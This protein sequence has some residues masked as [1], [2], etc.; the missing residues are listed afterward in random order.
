MPETASGAERVV[1]ALEAY[2]VAYVF[3]NPGTTE[4]PLLRA[5]A[6]SSVEYVLALHEDVAVAMAAGYAIGSRHAGAT[7]RPVGV[8]NLH[9]APGVAH[10]LGNLY[11]ADRAGAPVLVT[12]GAHARDFQRSRP[13]LGGDLVAMTDQ[14]TKWARETDDPA[15]LPG[16]LRA[17]VEAAT[18]PPTGPGFLALPLD[19]QLAETEAAV[20]PLGNRAPPLTPAE[21]DVA[22]A[23]DAIAAAEAPVLV[24]GDRVAQDGSQAIDAAVRLAEATGARVH[25]EVLPAEASFPPRH[26]QWVSILP[27]DEDRIRTLL[28]ADTLILAGCDSLVPLTA[29]SAPLV[30]P[31]STVV[32]IGYPSDVHGLDLD[33]TV[34]VAGPPGEGLDRL[35]DRLEGAVDPEAIEARIDDL[36]AVRG[37]VQAVMAE[38]AAPEG[39]AADRL[40]KPAVVEALC[41]V[42]PEAYVVDEGVT[43][44]YALR[45]GMALEPGRYL[46]SKGAGLGFG[47]GAAL[48]V[49][50]AV[51]DRPVV[52]FVGD[53]SFL[54]YPQALYT[55]VRRS[56]DVTFLVVDNEGYRI[57]KDN[58][59]AMFDDATAEDYLGMDLA[60]PID[61]AGFGR[62][63]GVSAESVSTPGELEPALASAVE[64]D[65]PAL[66]VARVQD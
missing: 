43:A 10:G 36:E 32:E 46:F 19:V 26:P 5:L 39:D 66:V 58:L 23:A 64:R 17:A 34:R 27:P 65:G 18:T 50:L 33:P 49:A 37:F 16:D 7:D 8:A 4:L 42:A 53:G 9:V 30:D 61:I 31:E 45:A 60:P 21:G 14:F 6:D 22:V 2:G 54:Y 57:L 29:P 13:L 47:A 52:A 56:I 24:V 3:G 55:A 44:S 40:S 59:H 38:A 41:A 12:A 48:G 15:A 25:G 1:E 51:E 63:Q 28:D 62:A 20:E 35:A 11:N